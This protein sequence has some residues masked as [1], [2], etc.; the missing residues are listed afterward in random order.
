M[1]IK[2]M[3]YISQ[4][5]FFFHRQKSKE[6]YCYP[7]Y[8]SVTEKSFYNESTNLVK[9]QSDLIVIFLVYKMFFRLEVL[10]NR[11]KKFCIVLITSST[12]I[13]QYRTKLIQ[14]LL[15]NNIVSD[16]K[17]LTDFGYITCSTNYFTWIVYINNFS[18]LNF[19]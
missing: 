3:K 11:V 5:S 12:F 13:K 8:S 18:L 9:S 15:N 10:S 1:K 7:F 16:K 6:W 4:W 14:M 2:R 19:H 17:K